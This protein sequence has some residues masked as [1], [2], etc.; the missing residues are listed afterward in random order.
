[1]YRER[2]GSLGVDEAELGAVDREAERKVDEATELAKESPPPSLDL[3]ETEVWTDGG[4]SWR[5]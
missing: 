4:S 5:N 1:M 3:V 2:L